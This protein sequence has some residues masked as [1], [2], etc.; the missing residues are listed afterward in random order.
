M[1]NLA[2]NTA[3]IA[4]AQEIGRQIRA[5]V[6]KAEQAGLQ[7]AV[8]KEIGQRHDVQVVKTVRY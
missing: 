7:V 2:Q 3:S 5:W 4:E 6:L 8:T 1:R